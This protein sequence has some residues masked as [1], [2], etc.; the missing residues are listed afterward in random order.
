MPALVAKC[1]AYDRREW[2]ALGID[3]ADVPANG[4]SPGSAE[5]VMSDV[6]N[7]DGDDT[8]STL[9]GARL[10]AAKFFTCRNLSLAPMVA[11]PAQRM[12]GAEPPGDEQRA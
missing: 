6:Q 1:D 9:E 3:A 2:G 12:R 5:D 11:G 8:G 4:D 7:G 10:K